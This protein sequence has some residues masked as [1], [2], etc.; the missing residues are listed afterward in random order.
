MAEFSDKIQALMDEVYDAW[1]N[2]EN[3]GKD[4]W[5]VLGGFSEAHKVAV[6]FGNFNYQVE[7]GGIEQ[8]IYN[9]YFHDDAEQGRHK[10]GRFQRNESALRE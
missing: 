7:N 8:W 1:R 3:N 4:K 9:G 10:R 2:D 6:T 5:E